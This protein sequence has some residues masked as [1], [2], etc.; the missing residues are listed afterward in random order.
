MSLAAA[1][2]AR[3]ERLVPVYDPGR[4]VKPPIMRDVDGNVVPLT[5]DADFFARAAR[6]RQE[7]P[8]PVA[9]PAPGVSVVGEIVVVQGDDQLTEFDGTGYGVSERSLAQLSKRVVDTLGD[10]FEAITI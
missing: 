3:A 4:H 8:A 1:A 2:P 10:K 6:Y 9:A 5:E 7:H